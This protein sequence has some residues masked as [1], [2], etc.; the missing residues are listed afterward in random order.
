MYVCPSR[1][2][3]LIFCTRRALEAREGLVSRATPLN[4]RKEGSSDLAYSKLF[5]RPDLVE[6]RDLNLLLGNA[7]LAARA[8]IAVL[9]LSVTFL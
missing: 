5:Q 4:P 6:H 7:L 1:L 9:R 3:M 8:Y 2:G